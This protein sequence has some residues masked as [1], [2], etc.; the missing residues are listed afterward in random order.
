MNIKRFRKV[1]IEK[2]DP[3]KV[4]KNRD[5]PVNTLKC[6]Q[7]MTE[8]VSLEYVE[9]DL[10]SFYITEESDG[11][12]V[13][14]GALN[15]ENEKHVWLGLHLPNYNLVNRWGVISWLSGCEVR[16]A[17]GKELSV[18]Q[19]KFYTKDDFCIIE[20]DKTRV[21][22]LGETRSDYAKRYSPFFFGDKIVEKIK[23]A[24]FKDS[25]IEGMLC[26]FW[27]GCFWHDG[28]N[29]HFR[30]SPE[31]E[32]FDSIM[33]YCSADDEDVVYSFANQNSFAYFRTEE[34]VCLVIPFE[35]VRPIL[36]ENPYTL[37]STLRASLITWLKSERD[38]Q[39]AL[40]EASDEEKTAKNSVSQ[41]ETTASV[42][43]EISDLAKE[44]YSITTQCVSDPILRGLMRYNIRMDRRGFYLT[45][46]EV[47]LYRYSI[48]NAKILK[49]MI[50]NMKPIGLTVTTNEKYRVLR[51]VNALAVDLDMVI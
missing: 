29:Y 33:F 46:T 22:E 4:T 51:A 20:E 15:G 9:D 34:V 10:S 26:G 16:A 42:L 39:K 50:F 25:E 35:A 43:E 37:A 38:Y 13:A 8:L 18:F 6:F 31:A 44:I 41:P 30:L 24:V 17:N 2:I 45:S 21:N 32:N 40:L 19:R 5:I 11:F 49:A 14:I 1:K 48:E 47:I 28:E 7:D 36:R 3:M 23:K 12:L 27:P